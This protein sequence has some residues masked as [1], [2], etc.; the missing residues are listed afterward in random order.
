MPAVRLLPQDEGGL[1]LN[2]GR[3]GAVYLPAY[4]LR[5][6]VT[7]GTDHAVRQAVVDT[8]A[9]A[10]VFPNYVWSGL[11]R[12]GDIEWVAHP[13]D[14]SPR[15]DLPRVVI[16]GG[17]YPFRLGRGLVTPVEI[18]GAVLGPTPVFVQCLEDTRETPA[19]PEPITRLFVLGLG[20]LLHGRTL[21]VSAA[22][23]GGAWAAALA[24]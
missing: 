24:E 6:W 22:A 7:L 2:D 5:M 16:L 13:P 1:R 17:R 14:T 10:A 23:D 18:T 21:T 15:R 9:P 3:G 8:G 19:D 20:G 4:R 12:R 11:A